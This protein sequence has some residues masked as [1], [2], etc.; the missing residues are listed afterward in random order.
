MHFVSVEVPPQPPVLLFYHCCVQP[1][2]FCDVP[3]PI[4]SKI[5]RKHTR[6]LP[7]VQLLYI[8]KDG[9]QEQ[10]LRDLNIEL[11]TLR[12]IIENLVQIRDFTVI[13]LLQQQLGR[14]FD[15]TQ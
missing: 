3:R 15:K 10:I 9:T 8:K 6:L 2:F 13:Y 12:Q 14:G 5:V 4:P 1:L 7:H 11:L